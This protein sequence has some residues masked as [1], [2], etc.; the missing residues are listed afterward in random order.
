MKKLLIA[1]FVSWLLL[2]RLMLGH[3]GLLAYVGLH[4]VTTGIFLFLLWR[5]HPDMFRTGNKE[6]GS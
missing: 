6:D 4:L 2:S 3:W 1:V 5:V